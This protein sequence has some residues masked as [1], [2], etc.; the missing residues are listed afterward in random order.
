M[1]IVVLIIENIKVELSKGRCIYKSK[2]Y[3]HDLEVINIYIVTKAMRH[4]II[5][6]SFGFTSTRGK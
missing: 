4:C 2:A 5:F 1:K 3:Q 6:S